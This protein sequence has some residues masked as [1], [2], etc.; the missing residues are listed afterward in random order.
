LS[1]GPKPG[2]LNAPGTVRAA[3]VPLEKRD[4][5]LQARA[6]VRFETVVAL[7]ATKPYPVEMSRYGGRG[8]ER[9]PVTELLNGQ[10]TT[11]EV[12]VL[13]RYGRAEI[14]AGRISFLKP[15]TRREQTAPGSV[16]GVEVRVSAGFEAKH[17]YVLAAQGRVDNFALS[18]HTLDRD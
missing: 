4:G 12:P 3:D 9:V 17:G 18:V 10:T 13:A 14:A 7:S 5:S 6:D 11:R 8:L 2:E 1:G 15:V 16:S